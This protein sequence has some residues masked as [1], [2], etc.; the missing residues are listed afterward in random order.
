MFIRGSYFLE[1]VYSDTIHYDS[2]HGHCPLR[3]ASQQ[4]YLFLLKT[5]NM[6]KNVLQTQKIAIEFLEKVSIFLT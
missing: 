6:D 5:I 2:D 4:F 1:W 3:L